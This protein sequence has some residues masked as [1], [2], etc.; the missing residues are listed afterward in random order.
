M[1]HKSSYTAADDVD[2]P[3]DAMIPSTRLSHRR[4]SKNNDEQ[5]LI[6]IDN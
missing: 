4:S 1:S 5:V 2:V 6:L 3:R